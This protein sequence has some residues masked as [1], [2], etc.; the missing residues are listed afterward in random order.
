M[1]PNFDYWQ[2]LKLPS[3]RERV[4]ANREMSEVEWAEK[5]LAGVE[6][7]VV[8]AGKALRAARIAEAAGDRLPV[9]VGLVALIASVLFGL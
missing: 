4:A 5:H 6:A 1:D 7:Q 3:D 8:E 2:W 9:R